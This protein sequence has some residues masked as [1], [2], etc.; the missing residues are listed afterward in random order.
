MKAFWSKF[1]RAGHTFGFHPYDERAIQALQDKDRNSRIL[2]WSVDQAI[3]H[4]W[5]YDKPPYNSMLHKNLIPAP[6]FGNLRHAKVFILMLNPGYATDCYLEDH[7]DKGYKKVM[8]ENLKQG[9]IDFPRLD[10]NLLRSRGYR[11][12]RRALKP[13]IECVAQQTGIS[14]LEAASRVRRKVAVI[15]FCPYHSKDDPGSWIDKLPS[16]R[17]AER[18]VHQYLVRRA[19]RGNALLLVPRANSRWNLSRSRNVIIRS[20]G[21]RSSTLTRS[22][23]NRAMA[24]V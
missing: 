2:D 16:C 17:E 7:R 13:L 22:E 12:W 19:Q 5:S 4:E 8:I 9:L 1:W 20:T 11:Y 6:Y 3:A 21:Q 23:V 10:A 24:F 15:Q 18:Y 14:R